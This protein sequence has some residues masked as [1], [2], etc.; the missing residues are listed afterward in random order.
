MRTLVGAFL[1]TPSPE[2]PQIVRRGAD[3]SGRGAERLRN[4][5]RGRALSFPA[6]ARLPRVFLRSSTS[7][8]GGRS[9]RPQR[10]RFLSGSRRS[11]CG[12]PCFTREPGARSPPYFMAGFGRPLCP[13][14]A[15]R[16]SSRRQSLGKRSAEPRRR[17]ACRRR[18]VRCR[19]RH[20]RVT[21]I[22]AH[23][24]AWGWGARARTGAPWRPETPAVASQDCKHPRR[25]VSWGCP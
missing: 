4:R 7:R 10:L 17:N 9:G 13:H 16:S 3:R 5:E 21:P 1:Q 22:V 25:E 15:G 6:P 14:G 8:T 12:C 23:L 24:I 2:F 18:Q 19:R 20:R 11:P